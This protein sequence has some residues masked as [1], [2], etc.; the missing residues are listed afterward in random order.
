MAGSLGN[1]LASLFRGTTF[2]GLPPDTA[3]GEGFT[4]DPSLYTAGKSPPL[5]SGKNEDI[6]NAATPAMISELKKLLMTSTPPPTPIPPI[7]RR[8]GVP[9]TPTANQFLTPPGQ[10]KSLDIDTLLRL[11]RRG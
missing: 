10:G 7:V 4:H 3:F 9:F 5:F 8:P 11:L 6:L 2:A 1:S